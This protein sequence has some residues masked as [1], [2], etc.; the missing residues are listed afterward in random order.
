M[1]PTVLVEYTKEK[2]LK[3][4]PEEIS[5]TM[6]GKPRKISKGCYSAPQNVET[7]GESDG[8]C[9]PCHVDSEDSSAP[10]RRCISLNADQCDDFTAPK[11]VISISK[12]S[13]SERKALEVRLRSELDQLQAFQRKVLSM[14]TAAVNVVAT[15]GQVKKQGR[16]E[17]QVN[18]GSKGRFQPAKCVPPPVPARSNA[19]L[20]KQCETLLNR[21]M[22]HKHGWVFNVPVDPVKWNIPDYFDVIKHPMDLG[23]IK[24]RI[25]SGAYTSPWGFAADVRLTFTNAMTYN[26]PDN[27]VH[28]MADTMS[29]FF[30]TRWKAIEKKLPE[31]DE[32]FKHETKVPLPESQ[33]KKRNIAP[34]DHNAVTTD[35]VKQ[36]MTMEDR[37]R[38]G[39]LLVSWMGEL[40]AHI[41]DFLRQH[42]SNVNSEDEIEVDIHT[43]G[44]DT[45]S[46]LQK[47]L[48]DFL[49]ERKKSQQV[50]AEQC[51]MEVLN[52]SGVSNP[53][54]RPCRDTSDEPIE[55]DVD[56]CG[57][58]APVSSYPPVLVE[59]DA[60]LSGSKESSSSSSSS[61][62][63]SSSSDSD[64]STSYGSGSHEV[65]GSPGKAS[66]ENGRPDLTLDQEKSDVISSLDV[67]QQDASSKPA[68][69]GADVNAEGENAKSERQVSPD[70]LYRAA[71]L[72]SRFAD[73]IIRAREKTLNQSEKGD[74]EKLQRERE[75]L[76]R[77]KRE[78]KARLLAE[79]KAA[80]DARRQ[81]EAQAAAEAKRQRELE[82]EAARQALLKMEKSVEIDDSHILK[83]L[84][85][86]STAPA[87]H[88]LS[89]ADETSPDHSPDGMGGLKLGGSNPLEQLGLY[90]KVDEEEEEEEEGEPRR[91]PT[92]DEEEGEIN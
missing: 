25:A 67:N 9:S 13:S 20:M 59:N 14:S 72:R 79:A 63:D 5:M 4:T 90:M 73:T 74:P 8:F 53:S 88:M 24:T 27:S 71:L 18:C 49:L 80:E 57:H 34:L 89:S 33:L 7:M 81:A 6:T 85:M 40:P 38:L 2:Q 30:E 43:L 47:L 44:E 32:C 75:E 17:L 66:K 86:L 92:N 58:D 19:M 16:T 1:A 82:R 28:I 46:D 12:M 36:R 68:A 35:R 3:R 48:D 78:E 55:E 37:E 31:V 76:E 23:T 50:T 45:L 70:K 83:D 84:E 22:V 54:M 64:S 62:S 41:V 11:Q 10:K 15:N 91:L 56:I 65:V 29:K 39:T 21:L 87:D 69:V 42:C 26:S 51:D 77:Q 60:Q 61:D 52:V